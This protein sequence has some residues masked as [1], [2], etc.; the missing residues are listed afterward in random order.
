MMAILEQ[1]CPERGE[2]GGFEG[3]AKE[4][5]DSNEVLANEN[6]GVTVW[7]LCT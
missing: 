5:R 7:V 1:Y 6:K 2:K 3:I 4:A